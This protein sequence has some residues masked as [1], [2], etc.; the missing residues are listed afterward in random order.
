M[1]EL[2]HTAR[3]ERRGAPPRWPARAALLASLLA[4]SGCS[5]R[6]ETIVVDTLLDDDGAP[7]GT[8]TLRAAVAMAGP[9]DRIAFDAALDGGT[10]VLSTVGAAHSILPGEVYAGG[11]PTFQGYR[12]RDHG[13]SAIYARKDLTIDASALPSGITLRWGGGDASRARVLAVYGDLTMSNVTVTGGFSSAEPRDDV[14]QPYTL[15]RGGGLAVWGTA[16]LSRCTVHGNRVSGDEAGSRDRGAYGGGIYANGLDLQDVVVSGNAAAGYGAAG[17][18]VYSVGGADHASGTGNDT[19]LTR[20]AVTGNRVTAQHAYGGGIFTLS[21][22]PG[23]LATM[24][25]TN[26]TVARNLVEDHP[27]LPEAGQWYYRGGGVY[28]GGGSLSIVSSTIAENAVSG[29]SAVFGGKP[30]VGGGGL[31]AT[32]GDAHVVE[33]VWVRHSILAGNTLDGAAEDWFTGSLLFMTSGGYNL[34]GVL[35]VSQILVPVPDW[36]MLSRK[37]HPKT[38]DR[39]GV[40]LAEAL[41]VAAAEL[42]PSVLSA[43]TD[44]GQP[45]VLWYPPAALALDRI[46]S[47]DYALT[48]VSAGYAGFGASAD[49]FLVHVLARLRTDHVPPLEPTFGE[50]LGDLTGVTWYGPAV[51]WP[52]RPENYPWIDAW[53]SIDAEIAGRLGQV[54]LGDEFWG[55]FHTGPLGGVE[56]T[57]ARETR[58]YRLTSTDQR[59]A[60]RPAG[61]AGDVG[62]VER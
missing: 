8:T 34:L 58:T 20:C 33:N 43:G 24:R 45:A 19:A 2:A 18:G 26:C 23:N 46:P 11:P 40:A 62:A 57:V 29:P 60:A 27:G 50:S 55:G 61:P 9:R 44:A 41:D 3:G 21:G 39:D 5:E 32:I 51:A 35:D 52:S 22:G 56:L 37:H 49:D 53:R 36:M 59:G 10:I 25:L 7:D 15:A 28:I 17:G 54:I 14:A 12:D 6:G 4:V 48:H 38:G 47:T 13:A 1:G 30:N 42:H 31:A 16:R